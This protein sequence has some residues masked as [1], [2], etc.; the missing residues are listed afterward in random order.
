MFDLLS[1]ASSPKEK[2]LACT[3]RLCNVLQKILA[4]GEFKGI[5]LQQPVQLPVNLHIYTYEVGR[6]GY[7]TGH[8]HVNGRA[9]RSGVK[10]CICEHAH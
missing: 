3:S 7:S 10:L 9:L 4:E 5:T 1:V 8:A 6:W 2:V